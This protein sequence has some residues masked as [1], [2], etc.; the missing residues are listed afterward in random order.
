[1]I[2]ELDPLF[3]VANSSIIV[4]ALALDRLLNQHIVGKE[5]GIQ[6]KE[7]LKIKRSGMWK[8]GKN[9]MEFKTNV[10]E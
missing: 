3:T 8:P 1:M 10:S 9:K 5:S 6:Q 2:T 4:G 7:V